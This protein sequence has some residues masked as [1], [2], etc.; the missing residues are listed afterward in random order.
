[1]LTWELT[2]VN[3]TPNTLLWRL[4][5][6]VRP[7]DRVARRLA[8]GRCEWVGSRDG[9]PYKVERERVCYQRS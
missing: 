5:F 4:F 7:I 1:M 2:E 6:A 9:E 3:I 8:A